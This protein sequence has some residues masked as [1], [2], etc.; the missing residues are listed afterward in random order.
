MKYLFKRTKF[1]TD[2]RQ[3]SALAMVF[4]FWSVVLVLTLLGLFF[5]NYASIRV[6]TGPLQMHD[7]LLARSLL[8]DQ[9]KQ[10]AL[11]FGT[12]ILV[13][14]VLMAFYVMAYAHRMTG[15]VHKLNMILKKAADEQ[16]WPKHLSFRKSDAF[17]ELAKN[18]NHFVE[19]MKSKK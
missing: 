11:T 8:V 13:F 12:T 9:A 4:V 16:A 10:L 3:Q 15:P 6:D 19:A 1:I 14:I 7:Q 2:W 17:H 5:I 18:F